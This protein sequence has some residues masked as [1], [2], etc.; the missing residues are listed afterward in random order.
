MFLANSSALVRP[1][2]SNM[3][4]AGHCLLGKASSAPARKRLQSRYANGQRRSIEQ[5]RV[6][7]GFCCVFN[8]WHKAAGERKRGEM[9]RLYKTAESVGQVFHFHGPRCTGAQQLEF[10][11]CIQLREN[12]KAARVAGSVTPDRREAGQFAQVIRHRRAMRRRR[13]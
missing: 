13:E 10:I 4:A 2:G 6:R 3:L 8:N 12:F 11:S 1:L 5:N 7:H 9:A